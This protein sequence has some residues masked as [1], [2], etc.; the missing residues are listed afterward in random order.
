M[1]SFCKAL[2]GAT[3]GLAAVSLVSAGTDVR[4]G[5]AICVVSDSNACGLSDIKASELDSSVLIFPGG[6]TR[7]AFDDWSSNETDFYS[8]STY[9]FQ[10]F[11][12]A[13]S[14][15]KL[16]LWFQG[17]GACVNDDTCNFAI[18]CGFNTFYQNARPLSTGV[19]N[20]SDTNNMFNDYDIVH[21]PYCTGDL[22][23]GSNINGSTESVLDQFLNADECLNQNM[24]IYMNGYN[25]TVAAMKW[26]YANYPN[27]EEIV[28]GGY[29][30]GSLGAQIL[31]AFAADLWKVNANNIKYS[32]LADSY[33]G[34]LP[35]SYTGGELIRYYGSCDMDL[36]GPAKFEENCES[37][38]L[39]VIELM[40]S[41]IEYVS[42]AN[43]LFINSRGDKTQRYFYQ[44]VAEGVWAYPFAD[45]I[46]EDDYYSNVTAILDAYEKISTRVSTFIIAGT[47]H[48]FLDGYFYD[49]YTA[50]DNSSV[51]GPFINKWLVSTSA[52][53]ATST[54]GSSGATG[55]STGKTT[56]A[57]TK[58]SSQIA[59]AVLA[60]IAI[61]CLSL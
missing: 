36:K 48:V 24:S 35:S 53:E 6:D 45:L 44:L 59:A 50:L 5:D 13:E 51:L 41:M 15:K 60:V 31:S 61:V 26:A 40:T 43:W 55:S 32:V 27:P 29:S 33:V 11:P 38:A 58:I 17:G 57:A 28:I 20:R 46:P 21:F 1:V 42:D 18:Q 37:G 3:L 25:N 23:V 14:S 30:A 39:S 10:V 56:S 22:H 8:N 16:F 19:L 2:F 52:L 12:K 47:Q 54:E 4:E 7:C 34:V 9:F 49:N